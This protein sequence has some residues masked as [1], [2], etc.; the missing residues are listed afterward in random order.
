ML[1][2]K[3]YFPTQIMIAIYAGHE[4]ISGVSDKMK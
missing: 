4:I 2:D 1:N 3:S